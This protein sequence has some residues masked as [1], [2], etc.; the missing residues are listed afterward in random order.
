MI[1]IQSPNFLKCHDLYNRCQS[2]KIKCSINS[3][4]TTTITFNKVSEK[5]FRFIKYY[6]PELT[7]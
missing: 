4:T 6:L 2:E 1:I 7:L 5:L 3:G